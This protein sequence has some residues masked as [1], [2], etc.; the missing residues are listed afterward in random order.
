MT[1]ARSGG[2]RCPTAPGA[3]NTVHPTTSS[4]STDRGESVPPSPSATWR[5]GGW[6]VA[7][8]SWTCAGGSGAR[9][10]RRGGDRRHLAERQGT[11]H[12]DEHRGQAASV[13]PRLRRLAGAERVAARAPT[14]ATSAAAGASSSLGTSFEGVLR[15]HRPSKVDGEQGELR[16]SAMFTR[17]ST[18]T[19]RRWRRSCVRASPTRPS[20]YGRRRHGHADGDS[21]PRSRRA[22]A[23]PS[24]RRRRPGWNGPAITSPSSTSTP[25]GSSRRWASTSTAPTWP[26]PRRPTPWFTSTASCWAS[27]TG[28]VF[29]YPTWWS[30]PPAV[31]KGW[32]ER[33]FVPGVAFDFDDKRQD[34]PRPHP[35]PP[36][37]RHQ[38]LRLAVE[39]R[40]DRQRQRPADA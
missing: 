21:A 33:V 27:V 39:L 13:H 32:L 16:N 7:P 18:T 31:L 1:A 19:G 26:G 30:G 2:P 38:H 36:D 24:P 17:W 14:S 34:P 4:P 29:V 22:F 10:A 20:D 11:A 35:H 23:T 9:R 25:S 5:P 28:L 37:H 15:H 8:G 3:T 12:A 6:W 40:Q